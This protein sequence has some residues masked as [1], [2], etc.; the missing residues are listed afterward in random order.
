MREKTVR[1]ARVRR[2]VFRNTFLTVGVILLA[3]S[4]ALLLVWQW[5]IARDTQ[6]MDE[7]LRVLREVTPAPYSAVA[8]SRTDNTMPSL[9]VYGESFTAILTFPE[10]DAEFPV[11]S[12]FR[13]HG[14]YPCRY[15]GSVYDSSLVIRASNRPGQLDFLADLCV[16]ERVSVT[17]MTGARYSYTIAEIEYG[18]SVAD[19]AADDPY[20]LT[21]FVDNLYAVE[22]VCI[23][24]RAGG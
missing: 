4:L 6:R 9:S 21:L 10:R 14:R 8:E 16:G 13:S 3:S 19:N 7:V 5:T 11:G 17:D 1:T 20:A 18:A 22:T 24:C 23:R 2:N 12:S 15:T